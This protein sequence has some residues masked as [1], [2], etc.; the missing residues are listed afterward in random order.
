M[1][2]IY[3][4]VYLLC[5]CCSL[6]CVSSSVVHGVA[7]FLGVEESEKQAMR[8]E[9]RRRR[10]AGSIGKLK[11]QYFKPPEGLDEL[12]TARSIRDPLRMPSRRSTVSMERS[13]SGRRSLRKSSVAHM[14][15]KG[16]GNLVVSYCEVKN[17]CHVSCAFVLFVALLLLGHHLCLLF[18]FKFRAIFGYF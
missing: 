9:N 10:Y 17:L 15:L 3:T 12:D 16:V 8:W 13:V 5:T 14:A 6:R 4:Q 7:G 1:M 18:L 11:E 2:Q